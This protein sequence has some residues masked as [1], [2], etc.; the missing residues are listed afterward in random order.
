M[1]NYSIVQEKE[2]QMK[3]TLETLKAKASHG[4]HE[5]AQRSR[6]MVRGFIG[7]F[8]WDGRIVC[9]SIVYYNSIIA[10]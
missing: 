7:L 8:G 2:V 5:V 1:M 4:G 10:F 9:S 6:D 3:Q